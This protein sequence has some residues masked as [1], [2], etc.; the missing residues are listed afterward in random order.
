MSAT[1]TAARVLTVRQPWATLIATGRKR[2]ETRSMP[3]K[4]RGPVLI[5]A[6]ALSPSRTGWP[7][8]NPVIGNDRSGWLIG[9]VIGRDGLTNPRDLPLGA[10]IAVADLVDCL[11]IGY[12]QDAGR[13]HLCT[14]GGGLNAH[15]PL[16]E[17]WDDGETEHDH[18]DQ[19]P[20]GDFTH[21]RF[22]WMLDNVRPL[23]TPIPWKG[24]LGLRHAPA[25]LLDQ[26]EVLS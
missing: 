8:P 5:H 9:D 14:N 17:R 25:E 13:Y 6:G 18:D 12:C 19:L 2:I 20:Y 24:A 11:P 23:A 22:G 3:T 21:G 7:G 15:C 1:V 10:V 16:D 26:I 4:Y